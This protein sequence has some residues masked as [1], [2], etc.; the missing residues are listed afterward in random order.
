[1][2]NFSEAVSFELEPQGVSSTAVSPGITATE[3]LEVAGQDAT[4]YQRLMMMDAPTV[5]RIGIEAML[6]GRRSVVPGVLNTLAAWSVR[7]LPR[8]LMTRIAWWTMKDGGECVTPDR[9]TPGPPGDRSCGV[10]ELPVRGHRFCASRAGR[11]RRWTSDA[12]LVDLS[13]SIRSSP[14]TPSDTSP[15]PKGWPNHLASK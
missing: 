8:K 11:L 1:M 9:Q 13:D 7:L 10:S 3:F 2:L 5:A 6:A 12:S 4:L 14:S 15:T